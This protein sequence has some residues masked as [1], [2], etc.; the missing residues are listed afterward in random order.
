MKKFNPNKNIIVTLILVILAVTVL[1]LTIARRAV[2]ERASI[3]QIIVNDTVA[4]IDKTIYAPVRWVDNGVQT[5]QHLFITFDENERLKGKLAAYEELAQQNRD[6]QREIDTLKEELDLNAT[7]TSY[8]KMT[9]NVIS[10]SPDAWQDM[11]VIDKGSADGVGVNMAVMSQ[12]GL[13]GR[14]LEVNL[15]SSKVELL[16]AANQNSNHFPVRISTSDGGTFGLLK[17]YD[18][19]RDALVIE[20]LTGKTNIKKDDIVQTSGLG[21]N[22]PANLRVGTVIDADTDQFGLERK[23]YVK[24]Y[25]HLHDISFVTIIERTVGEE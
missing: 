18:P 20:Q 25:A 16:T 12:E 22:S 21:G 19:E 2:A 5:V 24:P 11:L 4:A 6:F 9:A 7:L 23:V 17:G 1:S 14:V 13:I 8:E 3:F 10:R 15:R